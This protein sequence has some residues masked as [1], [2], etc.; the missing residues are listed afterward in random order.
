MTDTTA[1]QRRSS[2]ANSGDTGAA[3]PA[4]GSATG[5][6]SMISSSGGSSSVMLPLRVLS[7]LPAI[8]TILLRV[9]FWPVFKLANLAFPSREFDG[10]S[11]TTA[12]DRAAR[13][14]VTMFQKQISTVRPA[15]NNVEGEAANQ[16]HYVEPACPFSPRGYNSTIGQI[17]S[18]PPNSR[19]LLLLY[20]HSPLHADG[21]KFIRDYLCHSQLLQL[22]NY[23][24]SSV[25]CFGASIHTADGQMIRDM[26]GVTSF[27]F[28]ALLNVKSSARSS[29]GSSVNNGNSNVTMELLL[30]MEGP[31]L[32]TIPPTQITVYLNTTITR[33]AELL[34]VEEARRLQ[35]EE[36]QLLREE[37]NREF[38]ETLLADQMREIERREAAEREQRAREEMEE[39]ERMKRAKEESRLEDAKSRVEGA[40]VEPP[41]GAKGIASL[42]FTLPNGKRV[43]RRFNA[44]DRVE[45]IR[46]YL[47]VHFHEQGIEMKN[48]SLS[49]SYP[50]KTFDEN[51]DNL[52]LDEAGLTPHAVVMVQDLDA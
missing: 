42:R 34:A 15:I 43:D 41:V 37:Q 27:P 1:T 5:P 8:V 24:S 30:R 19:P 17:T 4:T 22:L 52:T 31:K 25:V 2:S 9:L 51:D 44:T 46:A 32:L 14:F 40:G 20:L 21:T 11:N 38:Q 28:M 7:K 48:F 16:E 36:E 23:N 39:A 45:T 6:S 18:R 29:N 49:T 47:I 10:I 33:H 3:P 26:M 12:S 35:R 50:R 13:A